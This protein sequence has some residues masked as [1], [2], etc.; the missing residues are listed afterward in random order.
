VLSL[1]RVRTV[2]ESGESVISLGELEW[3]NFGFS[4]PKKVVTR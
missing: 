1:V 4:E 3:P 2:N